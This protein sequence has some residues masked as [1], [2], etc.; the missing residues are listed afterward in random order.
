MIEKNNVRL[1]ALEPADLDT[2]YSWENDMELWQASNTIVPFSRLQLKK[3]IQ[4]SSLDIYQTKQ[5]RL[6][7]EC[8]PV[9]EPVATVGMIDLFSFDPYHL[10][11]GVGIM[12]HSDYRGSGIATTALEL[13]V[14]YCFKKLGLH[15]L[16]CSIGTNNQ[17]SIRLFEKQGFR[18]VGVKKEWRRTLNG[19]EDEAFYQLIAV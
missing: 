13:F 8:T 10:R 15:Q 3:Y 4:H 11:A 17:P 5:L 14:D 16:F 19:F 18:L 2:L 12:L 1:R 6:M 7:V 9:N